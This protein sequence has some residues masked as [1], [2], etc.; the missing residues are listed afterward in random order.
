MY[1]GRSH[2]I[3]S[4]DHDTGSDSLNWSVRWVERRCSCDGDMAMPKS[5]GGDSSRL[6]AERSV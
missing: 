1:E 3:Y 5:W 4:D 2:N 6:R